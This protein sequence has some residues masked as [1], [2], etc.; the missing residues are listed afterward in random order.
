M[1]K[2]E[3][4][5][6]ARK[7]RSEGTSVKSISKELG[8][9]KSTASLWVRDII[10]SIEQLQKI[11][12]SWMTATEA[13]R[14][15]GSLMQKQRRIDLIKKMELFGEKSFKGLT[16]KEFFA[17]GVCLYWAEGSKKTRKLQICNSDPRLIIFM[18]E[19]FKRFFGLGTDRYSVRITMNQTQKDKEME[20]KKYWSEL[21]KIP[22]TSF[23]KTN[24]THVIPKKTFED[25]KDYH[26]VFDMSVLKPGELYY[27]ML[28]LIHGL[29]GVAQR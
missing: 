28:G 16:D 8:V 19:W 18:I 4:R 22:I 10:L 26:G 11:R 24:F 12:K 29:A 6:K 23:N 13:N 25:Y 3:L 2:S 17:A 27:K 9:A 15:K 14:L 1:S 20:I 5:I 21:T 7:M